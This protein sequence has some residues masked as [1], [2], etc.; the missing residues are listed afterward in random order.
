MEN[1]KIVYDLR[2]ILNLVERSKESMDGLKMGSLRE[3]IK[4]DRDTIYYR[5]G[6]DVGISYMEMQRDFL[7]MLINSYEK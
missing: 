4:L 5:M 3:E 1:E 2:K 6:I 7:K